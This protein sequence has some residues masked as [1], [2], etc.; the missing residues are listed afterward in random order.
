MTEVA[1]DAAASLADAAASL[2]AAGRLRA[3]TYPIDPI[4]SADLARLGGSPGALL[5][6]H[7]GDALAGLD[8]ALRIHFPNGVA[9]AGAPDVASQALDLIEV[10]DAV[11]SAGTGPVVIGALPF[12]RYAPAELVVP[13]RVIRRHR[14]GQTWLTVIRSADDDLGDTAAS[15]AQQWR[16]DMAT[17]L[18]V[19]PVPPPDGFS[20]RSGRPHDEWCEVVSATI[21]TI[22]AG[23]LAKVV[24]AREI[25]VEANRPFML[26]DVLG[27]LN[28]LYPSCMVF[29]V[30][31]F[32]G[33]SPELLVSRRGSVVLSH[34]LAGTVARSGDRVNDQQL[35]DALLASPKE[36][37]E[38]RLVVDAVAEA[39]HPYC[40]NLQVPAAP[41]IVEL[42]NVSHLGTRIEGR[43]HDERRATALE[44]AATLHPTPAV[45]GTPRED[46]LEYLRDH[47]GFDRGRYAGPVGWMDGNGDGDWAVGIRSA[48]IDGARA[49]LFAGVG[50]V[51]GSEARAELADLVRP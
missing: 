34:P 26:S 47:E 35:D 19:A 20:L 45:A 42:R 6:H 32:V 41:S 18:N 4:T 44:L 13:T 23:T 38:H 39:L 49:R 37:Q 11:G 12:D 8:V 31:G 28:A 48:E 30:D 51:G 15:A 33:A 2:A 17:R 7:D 25:L 3:T 43:L 24:M 29:A 22:R 27:R 14:D 1:T 9:E 40:A 16:S 10:D 36:R 21:D 46:A 50:V 5:W